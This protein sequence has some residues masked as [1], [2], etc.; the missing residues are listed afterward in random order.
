MFVHNAGTK[1]QCSIKHSV[2][3]VR[4]TDDCVKKTE[5]MHGNQITKFWV[6]ISILLNVFQI[7]KPTT[8]TK[9]IIYNYCLILCYKM[10]EKYEN[11]N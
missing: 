3:V 7:K 8:T 10:K 9:Q 1:I 2:A 4:F 11:K 5:I 6:F